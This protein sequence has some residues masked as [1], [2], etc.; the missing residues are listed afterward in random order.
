V[1]YQP[2]FGDEGEL[3]FFSRAAAGRSAVFMVGDWTKDFEGRPSDATVRLGAKVR[4]CGDD[5]ACVEA[6]MRMLSE[7]GV[8]RVTEWPSNAKRWGHAGGPL[9]TPPVEGHSVLTDGTYVRVAGAKDPAGD[10]ISETFTWQGHRVTVDAVGVVAIRFASDGKV[11][12]FGAGGLKSVRT[13][14][15]GLALEERTDLAFLTGADGRVRGLVQGWTGNLPEA[16]R[17]ITPDWQRIAVP[18]FHK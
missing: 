10:P 15:F 9:A 12:A 2:E 11:A 4:K 14:G 16:L 13:D 7:A 5:P 8:T 6:A 17:S 18:A 1:L 3:A